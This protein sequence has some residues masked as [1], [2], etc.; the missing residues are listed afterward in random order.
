MTSAHALVVA[1]CPQNMASAMHATA[2]LPSSVKA[3]GTVNVA[4]PTK[5]AAIGSFRLLIGEMPRAASR[6]E[7]A[8]PANDPRKPK[9]KGTEAANPICR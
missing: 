9:M 2:T 4:I 1:E 8:P 6:S 7:K 3:A 5:P